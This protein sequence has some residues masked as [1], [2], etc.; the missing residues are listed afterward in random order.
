MAIYIGR[1]DPQKGLPDLLDAA[2]HVV[3]QRP[4]WHL[5]LVGDGPDSGWLLEQIA[6]RIALRDK[7]HWLGPR[8]DVPSLLE[9]ADV[10][11]HSALWEGMPNVV[12]EAMAARRPVIGTAVEGTEDLVIPGETGWLVPP[13]DPASLGRALIE[14]AD[15][16]GLCRRYG[17]AG[18]LR[19]EKDFSL[20]S[21]VAAYEHLWA[22]ILGFQ[23]P[24]T[25][26]S[27][28]DS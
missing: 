20:E 17:E 18:R 14:A 23:L 5:A 24:G 15:S 9:S 8:P 2:E 22:G 11:V 12:L 10:L 27:P 6:R 21:T 7:I 4:D 28:N 19:V 25:D 26:A 3:G 16:P 1:L 13:R